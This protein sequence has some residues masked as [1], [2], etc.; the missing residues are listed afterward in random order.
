MKRTI[1]Y[2][3]V[4]AFVS[5]VLASTVSL[6]PYIELLLANRLNEESLNK[7]TGV[8]ASAEVRN[9]YH[10]VNKVPDPLLESQWTL[11]YTESARVWN[12]VEQKREIKVAVVDTGVDY[13]HPDLKNRVLKKLGYDFYNGD[14]DPMDDGWHGTHVA[15]IIAAESG[16]G[17]GISGITGSLDVKIIPVKVLDG[18]GQGPSGIIAEGIRYS[19]NK[20]AD[21]INLSINFDVKDEFIAD[22]IKYAWDKGV[23]VVV[24]SGNN[25]KNSD[26]NSPASDFGAFTVASINQAYEKSYFSS[27]GESVKVSAPGERILSTVPGGTYVNKEGTSMAA[28]AAA[29][30]AAIL[31]A[32]MPE[33]TPQQLTD[34]LIETSLNNVKTDSDKPIGSGTVNA[35]NALTKLLEMESINK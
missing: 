9:S 6:S 20:G 23:F 3:I 14:R 29:G 12:L 25:N 33:L 31:K 32:Q 13:N 16:N 19:V 18:S 10:E 28:P 11:K 30:I 27:F 34:I 2:V 17:I 22:A 8:S 15:G 7:S 35:Y 24:A 1:F 21:I 5:A 4:T 26:Y